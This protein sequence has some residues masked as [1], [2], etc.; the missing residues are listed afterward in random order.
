MQK[1]GVF[2]IERLKI[3]EV[4][5]HELSLVF[6]LAALTPAK[7]I[8]Y[9]L[10]LFYFHELESPEDLEITEVSLYTWR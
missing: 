1:Y 4:R 2:P 5:H 7:P 9:F 8:P 10:S 3:R 6:L